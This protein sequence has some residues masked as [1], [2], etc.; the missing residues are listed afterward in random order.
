MGTHRAPRAGLWKPASGIWSPLSRAR[1]KRGHGASKLFRGSIRP[2]LARIGDQRIADRI[3]LLRDHAVA[4]AR[5]HHDCHAVAELGLVGPGVLDMSE[6]I[7]VGLQVENRRI[8]AGK[9]LLARG[10]VAG[11][12]LGRQDLGIPAR[13][14]AARIIA[15]REEGEPICPERR[16]R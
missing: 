8:A 16:N 10:A 14:P 13:E 3:R 4:R 12:A 9:I 2:Q 1:H 6:R 11:A 5:D 15:G 7:V